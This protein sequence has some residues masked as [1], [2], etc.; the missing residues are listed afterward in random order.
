MID[1]MLVELFGQAAFG[2]LGKSRRAQLLVRP[3]F[4]IVGSF[5]GVAGAVFIAR[6]DDLGTNVAMRTS[7]IALFVFLSAFSLFNVAL[8]R[9]WRW[10]GCLFVLSFVMIIATRLMFGA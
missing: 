4:G 9:R 8:G 10:P 1:D 2:R 3:F 6:R 7:M 5:L